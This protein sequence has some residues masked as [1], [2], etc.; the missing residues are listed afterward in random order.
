MHRRSGLEARIR[1]TS[2]VALWLGE[3][4]SLAIVMLC[5]FIYFFKKL[6]DAVD[7]LFINVLL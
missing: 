2:V 4:F 1:A 6:V 3:Y 7:S 5:S